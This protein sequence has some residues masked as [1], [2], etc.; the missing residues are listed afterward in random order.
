MDVGARPALL[1]STVVLCAALA[2]EGL[3]GQ[4]SWTSRGPFGRGHNV[5]APLITVLSA[6]PSVPGVVYA[7]SSARTLAGDAAVYVYKSTDGGMVSS[8]ST[9][10]SAS[11][12]LSVNQIAVDPNGPGNIYLGTGRCEPVAPVSCSGGIYR[13]VDEG[14]SWVLSSSPGFVRALA[15][16]P[17][18]V[19][20]LYADVLTSS[21]TDVRTTGIRS[22]DSG[23]S[24]A[25]IG[26]GFPGKAVSQFLFDPSQ[27]GVIYVAS[28]AGVFKSVDQ[29]ATWTTFSTGLSSLFV[30]SLAIDPGRALT[31]YAATDAGLFKSADGALSWH[32][33]GFTN[34][35]GWVVVNPFNSR[36]LFVA[37]PTMGVLESLDGGQTWASVNTGLPDLIVQALV[38]DSDGKSLHAATL[39][40]GVF[41]YSLPRSPRALPFR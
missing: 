29:G 27:A 35:V 2:S 26:G 22:T 13:S 10:L 8:W 6:D 41:D 31:L 40:G 17:R 25:E 11:D 9:V 33:T 23:R 5:P 15:P 39:T 18:S 36:N 1:R 4:R 21:T 3:A 12:L 16:D 24:W 19:S 20:T 37:S 14:A 34:S 32:A 7:G 38:I 28:D 30:R